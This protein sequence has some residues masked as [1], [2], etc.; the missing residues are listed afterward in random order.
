M[1]GLKIVDLTGAESI[2]AGFL[3]GHVNNM[4]LKKV[5]I[6]ELKCLLK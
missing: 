5:W 6:K 4:S 1:K 2:A 3:H